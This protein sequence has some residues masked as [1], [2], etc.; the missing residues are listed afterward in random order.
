MIKW[1][2]SMD[3]QSLEEDC[4]NTFILKSEKKSKIC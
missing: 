3:V 2:E 4:K 1:D